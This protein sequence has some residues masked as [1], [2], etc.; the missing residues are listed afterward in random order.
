MK[1]KSLNLQY[2]W[3]ILQS[4][5]MASTDTNVSHSTI[6][7]HKLVMP[8]RVCLVSVFIFRISCFQDFVKEIVKTRSKIFL[9]LLF[10]SQNLENS[11]HRK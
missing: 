10:S 2:T 7:P 8:E 11:K 9:F 4:Y 6:V 3:S 5:S 1:K